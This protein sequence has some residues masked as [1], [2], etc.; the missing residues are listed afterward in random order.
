MDDKGGGGSGS[1]NIDV[2][3]DGFVRDFEVED[4]ESILKEKIQFMIFRLR[5]EIAI[6][7]RA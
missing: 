5:K 1:G 4:P 3:D 2:G 6:D 7:S